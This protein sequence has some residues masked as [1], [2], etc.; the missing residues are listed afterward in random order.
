MASRPTLS[1]IRSIAKSCLQSAKTEWWATKKQKSSRWYKDWNLT[2]DTKAPPELALPRHILQRLIAIRTNHGDF[3][4]YHK[5]FCHE[6]AKLE[7]SCGMDKTPDHIVHCRRTRRLFGQW[8][9]RPHWPPADRTEGLTYLSQ[10]LNNPQDFADF[11]QATN[12]Y[13]NICT[14]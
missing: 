3:A 13:T 14:R 1:G 11:L 2:Y 5:K 7:C 12:F 9:N 8:P 6:D 4:W 10:L